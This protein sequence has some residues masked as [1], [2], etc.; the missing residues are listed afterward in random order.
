MLA[1]AS[2]EGFLTNLNEM[3]EATDSSEQQWEAFLTEWSRLNGDVAKRVSEIVSDLRSG[4]PRPGAGAMMN[5]L[6]STL[7]ELVPDDI[8]FDGEVSDDSLK[9]RLGQA[10]KRKLSVRHGELGWR[11]EKGKP[12]T[13]NKVERWKVINNNDL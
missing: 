4:A 1:A 3:Y 11:V 9:K 2:V 12:D 5:P 8:R 6:F 7:R 13:D 10:L